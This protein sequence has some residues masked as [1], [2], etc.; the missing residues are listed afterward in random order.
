MK[1]Y[2]GLIRI[3]IDSN[4]VDMNV[5][6]SLIFVHYKQNWFRANVPR[7][8]NQAVESEIDV[9]IM[10]LFDNETILR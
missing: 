10:R 3:D 1:N 7:K 2:I 6:K 8:N 4:F 5:L 9:G